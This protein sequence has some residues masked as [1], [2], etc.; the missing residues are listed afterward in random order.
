MIPPLHRVW[1]GSFEEHLVV[2]R[3][4]SGAWA[5][6]LNDG[7]K[8]R[9]EGFPKLDDGFVRASLLGH[10]GFR[11]ESFHIAARQGSRLIRKLQKTFV[12][13]EQI[14]AALSVVAIVQR[15]D[16][17]ERQASRYELERSFHQPHKYN[18]QRAS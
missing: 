14:D 11:A 15:I 18:R 8:Q 6:S 1:N 10:I 12:V 9:V 5:L 7:K 17:I 4:M 2:F 3:Q 13:G 16:E